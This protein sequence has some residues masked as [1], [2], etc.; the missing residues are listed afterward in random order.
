MLPQHVALNGVYNIRNLQGNDMNVI[1]D[2]RASMSRF[3]TFALWG[4]VL[5]VGLVSILVGQDGTLWAV[6]VAAAIAAVPSVIYFTQGNTEI[7]RYLA[8]V[9][10][11]LMAAMLVLTLRGHAWQIDMHMYFFAVLA[12]LSIYCD[13]KVI[14]VTAGTIALH[15]L[16]FNFTVPSWVFPEGAAFGRVIFHAVVVVVESVALFWLAVK[17]REA[18]RTGEKAEQK[19]AEEAEHA[20]AEA[21]EAAKAKEQAEEALAAAKLAQEEVQNLEQGSEAERERLAQDASAER[22]RMADDFEQSMSGLMAEIAEVSHKLEEEAELLNRISSETENA[23]KAAT[24]ATGNVSGN[25]NAVASAAEEMSASIGEI[26]RQV[27]MSASVADTARGHAQDSEKRIH[28]LADRADKIN[29]V[30]KMIGDI[31]EQTNLLALN[32]TIEAARAGDA[33]KGFAVVASEVKSLANQSANATE[34]IGKLLAGIRDATGDAV[35]VN[36]Q[37][38][39]VVGQISE[40]SEG[41]AA[42]VQEQSSATEEIARSA[43]S[44]AADTIEAGRSVENMRAV[45]D[46]ISDAAKVTADAVSSLAEKTTSLSAKADEFTNSMRR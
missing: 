46:Q 2:I 38:V 3:L 18:F 24:G 17:L 39:E 28:E 42:A 12:L 8:S 36:K 44:A 32:A 35:N 20:R 30:L 33:G 34:E 19:A 7:L 21:A 16:I 41:I 45:A 11:V 43:Q 1:D 6:L 25:V 15:H 5:L 23:L 22:A 29:D 4:H 37:I 27:N 26:N 13:P 14:I 9:A 40:N 31:A 10:L